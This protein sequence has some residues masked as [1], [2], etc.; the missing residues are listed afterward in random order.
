MKL[1]IKSLTRETDYTTQEATE[2]QV[3]GKTIAFETYG[4]EPED[5][6]RCRDYSW[7]EPLIAKVATV[8]GAEVEIIKDEY[9]ENYEPN[10]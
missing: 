8:C 4:G 1:T 3:D 2:V 6:S 9:K 10:W 7:V 5:N